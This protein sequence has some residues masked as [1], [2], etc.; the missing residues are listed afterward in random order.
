MNK[1]VLL[2]QDVTGIKPHTT[3]PRLNINFNMAGC[4]TANIINYFFILKTV[5]EF[6]SI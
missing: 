1:I 3:S 4:T 6:T 5:K 2:Y